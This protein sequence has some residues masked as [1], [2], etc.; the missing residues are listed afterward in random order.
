VQLAEGEDRLFGTTTESDPFG[1]TTYETT[2]T[3]GFPGSEGAQPSSDCN[4]IMDAG[5]AFVG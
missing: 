5:I 3:E 4:G 2:T 1:D